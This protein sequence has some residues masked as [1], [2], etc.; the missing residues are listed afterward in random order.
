[1]ITE[2]FILNTAHTNHLA[3]ARYVLFAAL[4]MMLAGCSDS[5]SSS[6]PL[7]AELA[8]AC[9]N[10]DGGGI[11]RE[12]IALTGVGLRKGCEG[13]HHYNLFEPA[14]EDGDFS[15]GDPR[16]PAHGGFP[17]VLNA[18][19]FSDYT[20]KHRAVFLPE[21]EAGNPIPGSFRAADGDVGKA[22]DNFLFP[23]GTVI[24]KTFTY[25]DTSS[26][27]PTERI[28]ETRLLIKH[29]NHDNGEF[30]E[31]LP[32]IWAQDAGGRWR[33]S[34]QRTGGK[35]YDGAWH[36]EEP[37]GSG[38]DFSGQSDEFGY[39]IP[40]ASQCSNCHSNR[41]Q[42]PGS[43]PI[44]LKARML[45]RPYASEFSQFTNDPAELIGRNQIDYWT[46]QGWLVD[47][48]PQAYT[49]DNET[50]VITDI[51][52]IQ[53]YMIPADHNNPDADLTERARGYLMVNC[54]H[55]HNPGG[56]RVNN[57]YMDD[58]RDICDSNFVINVFGTL[59]KP[60]E[61]ARESSVFT[62]MARPA[63]VTAEDQEKLIEEGFT[64]S[65][66]P[67]SGRQLVHIQGRE[68]LREWIEGMD[69]AICNSD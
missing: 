62:R 16:R 40:G 10:H 29:D 33:A 32:Y 64:E 36:Y 56:R 31:G 22:Q 8:A 45:N 11:N 5:G 9:E 63:Q 2:D 43:A 44:G 67:Q 51:E 28:I 60:G 38:E 42:D 52:R 59:I 15:L 20:L 66:M 24:A 14:T 48:E 49:L 41:D 57:R 19:L 46:E 3:G 12:A 21:D 1:M 69:P 17:F 27:T 39:T 50:Q 30:W 54:A 13:L 65:A 35:F 18:R 26:G 58:I 47:I 34:L 25:P 23:V 61:D 4:V 53:P 7:S 37:F 68:L 6:G 55:C